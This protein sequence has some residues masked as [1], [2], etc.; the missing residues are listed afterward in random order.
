MAK[1]RIA[2]LILIKRRERKRKT[3]GKERRECLSCKSIPIIKC[4]GK[5][6]HHFLLSYNDWFRQNSSISA[7][8]MGEILISKDVLSFQMYPHIVLMNMVAWP[9][10][11]SA[12]KI[13]P[14]MVRVTSSWWARWHPVALR[15]SWE[16]HSNPPVAFWAKCIIIWS[17][18]GGN[19]S[20]IKTEPELYQPT[21][22][23]VLTRC[24][25]M[26]MSWETRKSWEMVPD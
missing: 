26:K 4:R 9:C 19:G 14:Q 8:A 15:T 10:R 11:N 21:C 1:I 7:K 24:Q 25:W 13:L 20:P 5:D 23:L 22:H 2:M 12:Q 18:S 16:G 3:H 6:Y 17:Q